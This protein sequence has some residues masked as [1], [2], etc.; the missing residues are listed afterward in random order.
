MTLLGEHASELDADL[1]GAKDGVNL[2]HALSMGFA[3]Q[4]VNGQIGN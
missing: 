3:G 1:T 4:V 2:S